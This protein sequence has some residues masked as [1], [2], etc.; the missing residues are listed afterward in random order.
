MG[1]QLLSFQN[2]KTVRGEPL[3]YLTAILYLSPYTESGETNVCPHASPGCARSCLY[4]AGMGSFEYVRGAR[5]RR[6]LYYLYQPEQF[7]A[8]LRREIAQAYER[9]RGRGLRLAVRLNGTSDL[10]GLSQRMAEEFDHLKQLVF[11]D[12]T[13]TPRP[14]ERTRR[15]L[16]LVFSRDEQNEADCL[17]ALAHG[18]NVAVVFSRKKCEPLPREWKGWPVIDGD[19]HDLRFLDEPGRIVGLRA[20]GE[21]KSD[22]TGFVVRLPPPAPGEVLPPPRF[23][24]PYRRLR[25]RRPGPKKKCPAGPAGHQPKLIT[26]EHG[27]AKRR[28]VRRTPARVRALGRA[29]EGYGTR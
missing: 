1:I 23:E 6:T 24:N 5:R 18:V 25:Y 8:Q 22:D 29:D 3:G 14:W 9:A 26:P 7:Y 4:T 20:K 16:H 21:A 15:N 12:Y 27:L 13:K 10:G 17:E 28:S 2:A 11:Y 19:E